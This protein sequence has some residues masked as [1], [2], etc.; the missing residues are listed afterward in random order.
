MMP[1]SMLCFVGVW[2]NSCAVQSASVDQ[3]SEPNAS[4]LVDLGVSSL[5]E[6]NLS[7]G[8]SRFFRC[9]FAVFACSGRTFCA[10]AEGFIF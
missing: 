4:P 2:T 1:V 7:R 3:T 10:E 6:V 9:F 8:F 5:K